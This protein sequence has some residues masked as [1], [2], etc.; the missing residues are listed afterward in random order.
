[1][2]H[3]RL[4]AQFKKL[5]V[6]YLLCRHPPL[7]PSNADLHTVTRIWNTSYENLNY[8]GIGKKAKQLAFYCNELGKFA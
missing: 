4:I 8:Q 3:I 2:N 6:I 1:M 5:K 7:K